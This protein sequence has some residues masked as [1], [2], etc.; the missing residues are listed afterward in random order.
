[1]KTKRI[2]ITGA[3]GFIG[4]NLARR[5]VGARHA[6][7]LHRATNIHIIRRPT[8]DT[9]R[10]CDIRHALHEHEGDITDFSFV[11]S[12]MKKVKPDIIFHTA[13]YG[14]YSFQKDEGLTLA[15]NINGTVNL[16]NASL[17]V[18]YE[19]FINV[20]SS[21]EYGP[22]DGP[23]REDDML[24]PVDTYGVSKAAATLYAQAM[25]QAHRKP[26][27][28]IRPFSVFGPYEDPRR[29]I[30]SIIHACLT[31]AGMKVRSPE[32]VRD[33][34]YIDDAID[35]FLTVASRRTS[36]GII[37][38]GGGRQ[39]SV[40]EMIGIVSRVTGKKLCAHYERGPRPRLD[41]NPWQ[42]DMSK[43]RRLLRWR[44]KTSFEEGI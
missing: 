33:Y 20:G 2:L 23:M 35:F 43:A 38:L 22:K 40:R 24:T 7:P 14:G 6:S 18:D 8:S 29:L 1:M 12:V 39:R 28:T 44:M 13:I 3:T 27:T 21:S 5:L 42:A 15:T 30:P 4:A 10:I 36:L 31:G 17:P 25:A 26:I 32:A 34:I 19:T 9:W 16:V 37:N 41:P 11:R